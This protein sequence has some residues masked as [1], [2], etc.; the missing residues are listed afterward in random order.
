[1]NNNIETGREVPGVGQHA[2]SRKPS[3][4]AGRVFLGV[5]YLRCSATYGLYQGAGAKFRLTFVS[6]RP[7]GREACA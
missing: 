4:A 6:V 7:E 2:I 1:M 5:Q 3:I